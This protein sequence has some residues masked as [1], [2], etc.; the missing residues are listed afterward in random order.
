M[1]KLSILFFMLTA[2][3]ITLISNCGSTSPSPTAPTMSSS[4]NDKKNSRALLLAEKGAL[5]EEIIPKLGGHTESQRLLKIATFEAALEQYKKVLQAHPKLNE[6][7]IEIIRD[8]LTVNQPVTEITVEKI[9]PVT[10]TTTDDWMHYHLPY[11]ST[12]N[13][14]A[15]ITFVDYANASLGGGTFST[16]WVQEEQMVA[17]CTD[18][19]LLLVGQPV[20]GTDDALKNANLDYITRITRK[21]NVLSPRPKYIKNIRCSTGTPKGTTFWK[22]IAEITHTDN[23][24]AINILAMAAVNVKSDGQSDYNLEDIVDLFS[25]IYRGFELVK[26]TNVGKK[27]VIISGRFGAGAF[28]HSV[29]MS[30]ALQILV[31]RI[32]GID[33][34]ILTARPGGRADVREDDLYKVPEEEVEKFIKKN[35]NLKDMKIEE[36]LELFLK[37][38]AGRTRWQKNTDHI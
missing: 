37:R 35:N 15:V 38:I 6:E 26:N 30:A 24:P 19:A 1:Q 11:T 17:F 25:N 12:K 31:A 14:D 36:V 23:P 20:S 34:L 13:P 9:Y 27:N 3:F 32:I 8:D 28:G 2:G 29:Y 4:V 18:L 7:K 21:P 5:L 10:I 16:G 22:N 33:E